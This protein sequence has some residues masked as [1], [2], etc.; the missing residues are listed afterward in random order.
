MRFRTYCSVSWTR[1][2]RILVGCMNCRSMPDDWCSTANQRDLFDYMMFELRCLLFQTTGPRRASDKPSATSS[3]SSPSSSSTTS[4][5]TTPTCAH[6]YHVV[7]TCAPS[8]HVVSTCAPSYHVVSACALSK[9][10]SYTRICAAHILGAAIPGGV[11]HASVMCAGDLADAPSLRPAAGGSTYAADH[12]DLSS[13][14]RSEVAV[15]QEVS[16]HWGVVT[17]SSL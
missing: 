14:V 5:R 11:V 3:C 9:S 15:K 17:Y 1:K 4:S 13:S 12:R 2:R 10:R 16:S 8:Y 7:S 6:S